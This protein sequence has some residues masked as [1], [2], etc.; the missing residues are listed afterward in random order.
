MSIDS[1]KLSEEIEE[2]KKIN[3]LDLQE[4]LKKELNN[5]SDRG[6]AIVCASILDEQLKDVLSSFFIENDRA[7]K[8]LF[9]TG[10]P[11]ST[12]SSKIKMS[13]YLGLITENEYKNIEM[14]RKIRN[15][16]AHRITGISFSDSSVKNRCNHLS[17]PKEQYFPEKIK[18]IP[19]PND[20]GS[21]PKINL[22]PFTKD[23]PPRDRFVQVF[24]YLS[25]NFYVRSIDTKKIQ[26]EEFKLEATRADF[27]KNLAETYINSQKRIAE[28]REERNKRRREA[29]KQ[30]IIEPKSELEKVLDDAVELHIYLA[31]VLE[32]SYKD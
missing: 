20:D 18:D 8:E 19:L 16:F 11:L 32:N 4:E 22:D 2:L 14:I 12:F 26:R 17:I 1:Q 29:G 28:L 15:D 23:T 5:Q 25:L 13:Y 6:V 27:F 10:E 3:G 7:K 9:N 31:R 30:E 24:T 21:L